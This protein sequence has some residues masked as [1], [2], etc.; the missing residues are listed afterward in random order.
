MSHAPDADKSTEPPRAVTD[1]V[2][3]NVQPDWIVLG[4]LT[5]TRSRP[6]VLI[7]C[8]GPSDARAMRHLTTWC[9]PPFH[10][11]VLPGP[12]ELPA[13]RHGT[14]VLEDVA[15]MTL[16]QQVTL[17]DWLSAGT[18]EMQVVSIASAPL[19][20]LVGDGRFLEGLFYRLNVIRLDAS[21]VPAMPPRGHLAERRRPHA[22]DST[23]PLTIPE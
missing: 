19:R 16:T 7:E 6:S 8:A 1:S 11:C 5:A 10:T 9:S 21:R 4:W 12:L 2:D 3:F 20:R 15:A 23:R 22:V 13:T 14:L 18:A 17:F